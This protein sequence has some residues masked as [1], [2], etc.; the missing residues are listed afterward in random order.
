[1]E[2]RTPRFDELLDKILENLKPHTRTCKWR[3]EHMHC[4]GEFEITAEDISFLKMLRVPPPNF[5]PTCR[6]MKRFVHMNALRFFKRPCK[7]PNH[8]E[9][10]ISIFPEECPFPVFDYKYF[11]SDEFDAFAYGQ[12]YK[13]SASPMNL[14]Y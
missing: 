2:S 9:L 10:M 3:E 13:K 1:M 6:R 12:E 5:C 8:N 4:E 14:L 11:I 7:A